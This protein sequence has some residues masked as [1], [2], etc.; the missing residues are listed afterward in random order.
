MIALR[1]KFKVSEASEEKR[2]KFI[3]ICARYKSD[4]NE[5]RSQALADAIAELEG[6]VHHIIKKKYS[7]YGKYYEDLV[8]E[9]KIG[10]IQGMQKYDPTITLPSTYF[11]VYI[12]HEISKFIDTEINRTTSHYSSNLMKINKIIDRFTQEGREWTPSDIAIE[13][14]IKMET[15][16]QCL[17]IKECNKEKYYESAEMMER[18]IT[19]KDKSPEEQ[20]L[21]NEKLDTIYKAIG[22]LDSLERTVIMMKYGIGY[23]QSYSYKTISEELDVPI[24]K[25]KKIRH[26]CIRKLKDNMHIKTFFK[27]YTKGS[28]YSLLDSTEIS[29]VPEQI[30]E[31]TMDEL[32]NMEFDMSDLML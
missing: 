23:P 5:I 3:D 24:E 21:E 18:D 14:G 16:I 28:E 32:E 27:D 7:T 30:A 2:A 10:I 1:T 29:I 4:D 20:I 11:N 19:Q 15:I 22:N 31:S 26:D 25:I 6:F 17:Q 8:Q 9:G 12:I 13:S